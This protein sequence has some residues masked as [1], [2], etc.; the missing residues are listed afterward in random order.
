MKWFVDHYLRTC[1]H[2]SVLDVGSYNVNGCYRDLFN[3]DRFDYTGLDME[4]G[5]NVD[6]VPASVYEWKEVG[7]D[8][9]DVVISGQALEHIEFFWI[10]V[11]EM[12]RA[13]KRG[14]LL[15]IIAPNGFGEHRYPVD[16]WRFFSDGMVALARYTNLEILHAHT[17][18]GPSEE[19]AEWFS[20]DCADSVL[21]ARKPYSGNTQI[22]NLSNYQCNP[23]DLELLR[24]PF[25]PQPQNSPTATTTA[26][27]TEATP[28][29][30][31][32]MARRIG[33]RL[34]RL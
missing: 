7:S 13:L 29:V 26:N 17:N 10:T 22:L 3:S 27:K 25:T 2:A 11:S 14:G 6:L 12:V 31:R 1:P 33:Y 16:C 20:D 8:T 30:L 4:D 23:A 9:Y 32:R 15:C 28:G 24:K 21:I 19:H 34:I 5:P 18:C